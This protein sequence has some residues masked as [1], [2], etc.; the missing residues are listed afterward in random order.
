MN[1]I[2]QFYN[3]NPFP[4]HY[5]LDDL[6]KYDKGITNRYIKTID[7]HLRADA[8]ILDIGCGTGLLTNL[9]ARKYRSTFLGVDFSNATD[10]AR[11]FANTNDIKNV[12]FVK[13]DFFEYDPICNTQFDIIV[14][15]SFVTHVPN[16]QEAFSKIRRHLKP[17]GILIIGV[18][19]NYGKILKKFFKIK[20]F[21]KRLELDQEENP[22]EVSF[23]NKHILQ[24]FSN[25]KLLEVMPSYKNKFIQLFALINSKNGG[26]TMYVFKNE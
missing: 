4:G 18:Y 12:N 7:K 2:K 26:L 13:K 24:E 14:A 23:T 15:Q 21:N 8:K 16:Y 11:H 20:Y 6:R 5:T 17:G 3:D 10:Y 22:F 9:F 19:N 25:Y 1:S